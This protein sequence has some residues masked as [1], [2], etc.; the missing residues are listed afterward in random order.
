[1]RAVRVVGDDVGVVEVP[2]PT[3]DGVRVRVVSA[4]ICGSDL[5]LMRTDLVR[6]I[7]L[8]HEFAGITEDGIAVAVEPLQPCEDCKSC[9]RG[10]YNLCTR[11][12]AMLIGI[13]MDGGM[14]DEVIVPRRALVPLP[15]GVAPADA[16]LVEPLAVLVHA[17]RRVGLVSGMRVAV[18]GGGT[19]GLCA[20][21]A[22]RAAGCDVTLLARHDHQRHAGERLGASVT[23]DGDYDVVFECAGTGDALARS[24]EL[25]R[26]GGTI[27][28]PGIYWQD[29]ALAGLAFCFKQL[30][31]SPVTLYGRTAGGRDVDAAAALLASNHEIAATLI[32]HRFALDD[33]SAAFAAAGD[34]K[35]GAIKV[36]LE[37]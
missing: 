23:V 5:H 25:M 21:A 7:T 37:P 12:S 9:R 20:V 30:T 15:A 32:T 24:V 14:A 33:A 18:I 35:S 28:V 17:T 11:S 2:S 4:G 27:S 22:I 16:C 13:G 8:G 29:V 10:E 31:L 26:P 34:R 36:V 3:G 1:M 19:I 6:G